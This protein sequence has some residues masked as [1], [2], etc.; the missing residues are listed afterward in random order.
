[1]M[2]KHDLPSQIGDFANSFAYS[3]TLN[4]QRATVENGDLCGILVITL[5]IIRKRNT[6]HD[7]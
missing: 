7:V 2:T 3:Y 4:Y 6:Q 1:M 5:Y